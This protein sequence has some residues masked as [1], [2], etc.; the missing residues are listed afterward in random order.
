MKPTIDDRE[1]DRRI[2]DLQEAGM[3]LAAKA[4]LRERSFREKHA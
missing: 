4:L 3:M 2:A 1:L